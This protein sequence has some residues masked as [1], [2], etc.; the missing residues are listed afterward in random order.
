MSAKERVLIYVLRRDLRVA[1]NPIFHEVSK[2]AQQSQRPFTHF[3][4]VYIFPANQVEVSGFVAGPG[5]RS[6]YPDA[7]S[8]VGGFW[9]CGPHRSRFL[10][11]G[12]WDTKK[13]LEKI[14]SDLTIRVGTIK[15]AVS[16]LLQ[17]FAE[18]DANA[19]VPAIW[20]TAEEGVEE[21]REERDVK[22][23]CSE[24]KADFKLWK[25]EKYFVDE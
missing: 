25:D 6:P 21:K 10:A 11:E 24:F 8:E 22:K 18:S 20:M 14:K 15:D 4:P 13:D 17:G 19:E 12:V 16:Q 2:L 9:R 3:L 23:L 5:K 7:R 1:D